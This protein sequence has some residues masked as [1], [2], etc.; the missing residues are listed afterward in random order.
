MST[1]SPAGAET[2]RLPPIAWLTTTALALVLTGGIYLAA[3]LPGHP[4]LGPAVGLASAAAAL[5]C[6]G[7]AWLATVRG[8][9]W[10][11]FRRVA[12]AT[13]AVYLVIAGILEYVFVLD[14]TRGATLGLFTAMLAL[15]AVSVPLLLA[16]SVARY[17]HD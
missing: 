10:R 3:Q 4:P 7:L 2:P 14:H 9:A 6:L 8:F 12:G 16:F 11:T 17:T 15:F 13:L 1:T 5:N